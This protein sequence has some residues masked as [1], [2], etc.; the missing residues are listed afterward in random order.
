[1]NVSESG[2]YFEP[3]VKLVTTKSKSDLGVWVEKFLRTGTAEGKSVPLQVERHSFLSNVY[4]RCDSSSKMK[5]Q[6]A[7]ADLLERTV[8]FS[9]TSAAECEYYFYI[10]SL[11]SV[12]RND[13]V[14]ERLRGWLFNRQF[15]GW[16]FEVFDL[17]TCIILSTSAYDSDEEWTNFLLETLPR[18]ENFRDY[19]NAAFRALLQ[20]RGLKCV[21]LLPE[22]V[23]ALDLDDEMNRPPLGYLIREACRRF[24]ETSFVKQ[25]DAAFT[26]FGHVE[27]NSRKKLIV[28]IKFERLIREELRQL[29]ERVISKIRRNLRTFWEKAFPPL[30]DSRPDEMAVIL[31]DIMEICTKWKFWDQ[32]LI[33]D[34]IKILC[35]LE[36]LFEFPI[37][38]ET[39]QQIFA[40]EPD[41]YHDSAAF[42]K[43]KDE[44]EGEAFYAELKAREDQRV[45]AQTSGLGSFYNSDIFLSD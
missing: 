37:S 1:M 3:F 40:S 22:I 7:F 33:R 45:F 11:A 21:R 17:Y 15:K 35:F 28:A 2:S 23:H 41:R 13:R 27:R 12:V 31:R 4:I 44:V 24:G 19:S 36:D 26:A 9:K 42:T 14:K 10:I 25:V 43:F 32:S 30:G 29:D 6:A 39:Y 34:D 38:D 16:R 18:D 20:R 8:P 5:F